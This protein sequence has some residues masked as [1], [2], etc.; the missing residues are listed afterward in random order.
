[1]AC[2]HLHDLPEVVP[3]S[4]R[5]E[6]CIEIGAEWAQLRM[7]LLCGRVGCC[8]ASPNRHAAKHAADCGH[9]LVRSVEPGDS[10]RWCYVDEEYV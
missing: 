5:C 7:C 4:R 1:M 3:D 6:A 9:A 2:T 10:W 8:D